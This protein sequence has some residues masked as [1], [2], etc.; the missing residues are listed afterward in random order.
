MTPTR[1][2]QKWP[3]YIR[4]KNGDGDTYACLAFPKALYPDVSCFMEVIPD[5]SMYVCFVND[6]LS[7]YKEEKAGE[8]HNYI[9]NV[10]R[11]ERRDARSVLKDTISEVKNGISRMRAVVKGK[12][13]YEQA[14]NDYLVGY[15]DFHMTGIGDRY[16]LGEIGLG[17]TR[18]T[19]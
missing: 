13:P 8:K 6:V 4:E 19:E 3:W 9:H 12:Q 10:A 2:G 11:Y 5:L 1:G 7:F 18:E 15:I 16:L 17:D 14:L